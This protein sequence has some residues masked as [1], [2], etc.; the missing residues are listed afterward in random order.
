[1]GAKRISIVSLENGFDPSPWNDSDQSV[2]VSGIFRV[3]A[4][5]KGLSL[6]RTCDDGV[7]E[8]E[9][10]VG[11]VATSDA[12]LAGSLR[13]AEEEPVVPLGLARW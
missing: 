11:V 13:R 12:S 8:E 3:A 2:D 10:E 7:V 9:V 1:M 6:N 4:G 5:P